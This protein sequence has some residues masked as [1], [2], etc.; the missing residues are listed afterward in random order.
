MEG[1]EGLRGGRGIV[2]WRY[3]EGAGG[4]LAGGRD[5]GGGTG[6]VRVGGWWGN[7]GGGTSC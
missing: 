2:E 7:A 5:R 1:I 6:E 3:R 4:G